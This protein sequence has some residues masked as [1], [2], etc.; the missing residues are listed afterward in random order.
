M[1]DK[2]RLNSFYAVKRILQGAYSNLTMPKGLS[3]IDRAFSEAII[4]G[5][6]ERKITLAYVISKSVQRE[7][8]ED[9]TALLM[10]GIYQIL[11]MDR[12][13]D[14][15]VCN[16]SVTIA[17]ELFGTKTAGFVNAVLR[18][19]CRNKSALIAD[20]NN[21]SADIKYSVNAELYK[22]IKDQYPNDAE[23]IFEAYFNINPTFLR[24]N[25]LKS[26]A[27]DVAKQTNGTVVNEKCVK[28]SSAADA[29]KL[30]DTG[31]FYIQGKASQIAVETLDAK[32][33][34]TVVDVCAC[35]GGKS[36][37]AAI[38]MQN[39]GKVYSFDL[40]KSKLSLIEKSASK[41]D[42]N[43]IEVAERNAK[44]PN[45]KMEG[46]A[47]RVIC[48]VPCSGTGVIGTKPEIKYKS[49]KD[50]TGLYSTQFEIINNAAKYLKKGGIMVYSTCSINKLENENTVNRFLNENFGYSLEYQETFMPFGEACEGFYIAK[51]IREK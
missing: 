38:D 37:G 42:I 22:L 31:C 21:A 5:T 26:N 19:V 14:N 47:D 34:H 36:L 29:V 30:L 33:N 3:G 39:K 24:V 43:I 46:I 12:V 41:L 2:A 15:A 35:P 11:Y 10:T 45:P 23:N 49:P 13:P 40:H 8:A 32:P 20:V 44:A 16:E 7:P 9:V 4:I 27:A 6:L 28:T 17:K 1:S 50:F 25:T 18:N 51:I 48:D